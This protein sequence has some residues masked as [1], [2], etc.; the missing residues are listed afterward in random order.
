MPTKTKRLVEDNLTGRFEAVQEALNT[1]L[2]ADGG[3]SKRRDASK[4]YLKLLCLTAHSGNGDDIEKMV[5]EIEERFKSR[6]GIQSNRDLSMI[7]DA[8]LKTKSRK[9][10]LDIINKNGLQM[11][12]NLLKRYRKEIN[13]IPILR[14]LLKVLEY[15]DET[16]ILSLENILKPSPNGVES[17]KESILSL[18]EHTTSRS[19]KLHEISVIGGSLGLLEK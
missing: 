15:L 7:M 11:L 8:F 1:L 9:I 3:I 12:H 16:K 14:K 17:F 19:T 5:T 13:K 2:N 4:G 10:L 6:E 18:T